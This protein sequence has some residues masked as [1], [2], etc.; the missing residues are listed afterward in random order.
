M[1]MLG[2]ADRGDFVA[3]GDAYSVV[4]DSSS[5][6]LSCSVGIS[7]T[8]IV[9]PSKAALSASLLIIRRPTEGLGASRVGPE[10]NP[11]EGNQRK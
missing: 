1:P 4:R 6:K 9:C 8:G 3:A 7:F 11:L 10:S 5:S 2:E